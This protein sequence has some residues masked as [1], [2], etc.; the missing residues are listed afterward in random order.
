MP[1]RHVDPHRRRGHRYDQG[2]RFGRSKFGQFMAR[3]IAR[4]TDPILFR[5]SKGRI[6][7][8]PIVNAPLRTTG[9][10]SGKPREVQLTYFHDGS[11]VILVA[12]NF[13]GSSHPQWYHNLKANPECT[14]GQEPF[15]AAEVT[16]AEEHR[17]LYELAERV[18]AGY[19]DYREKTSVT[20]RDIP[21]FRL[22]PR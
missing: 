21:V 7:M 12:S 11:D 1:L 6:N 8:G 3:H 10:K 17:R 2:V 9:A 15:T 13:G 19:R 20:G 4:R 16:D 22:T 5:L 14:F 18:Y